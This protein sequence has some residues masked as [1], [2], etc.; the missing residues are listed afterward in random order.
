MADMKDDEL[1]KSLLQRVCSL[2]ERAS[3]LERALLEFL[4]RTSQSRLDAEFW[5]IHELTRNMDRRSGEARKIWKEYWAKKRLARELEGAKPEVRTP[6]S[7]R[8]TIE[9]LERSI[10]ALRLRV[11]KGI[12][13]NGKDKGKLLLKEQV[14]GYEKRIQESE[15]RLR[16]L[17]KELDFLTGGK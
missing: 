14:E 5:R 11:K 12:I 2:E 10:N 15:E 13:W 8:W 9:S 7:I 16:D 1:I 4:P 6:K 17:K 3:R